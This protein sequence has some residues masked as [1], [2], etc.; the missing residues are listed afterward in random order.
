MMIFCKDITASKIV[1]VLGVNRST[2]NRYFLVRSSLMSCTFA[3]THLV[4]TDRV[5]R[6]F[7]ILALA[8]YWRIS[9]GMW[10]ACLRLSYKTTINPFAI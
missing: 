9:F 5:E 6:L 8:S 4:H 2:I 1:L 3:K 10:N 7:M